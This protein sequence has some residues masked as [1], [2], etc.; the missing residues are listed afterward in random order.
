MQLPD[1]FNEDIM[2]I[3]DLKH[4]S[5]DQLN[6]IAN[7]QMVKHRLYSFTQGGVSGLGGVVLLGGDIPA[8]AVINIRIVQLIAMTIW[9]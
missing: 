1:V 8:M 3:T 4:L 7:Q 6:Y 5:I 2:T 9:V